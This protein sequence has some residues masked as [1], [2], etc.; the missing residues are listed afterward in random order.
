MGVQGI[1]GAD[2]SADG[3]GGKQLASFWDLVGFF[4]HSEL[5]PDFFALVREA[6]QQMGG[7][8]FSRPGPSHRFAIDGEGIGGRGEA[9]G[10]DPHREHLLNRLSA[11]LRK[12]PAIE[13]SGFA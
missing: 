12:Q 6:G 7:I 1:K 3:Q 9:G 10:P 4:A 5:G 8:S 13:R 11:D 2:A